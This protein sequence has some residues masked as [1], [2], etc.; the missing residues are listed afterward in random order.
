[1]RTF[2]TVTGVLSILACSSIAHAAAWTPL[3]PMSTPRSTHAATL[4]A[5]GRVLVAGGDDRYGASAEVFDPATGH[6]SPTGPMTAVRFFVAA[7]LMP[8]GKVLAVGQG[9]DGTPTPKHAE[10]YDPGTN[11]WTATSQLFFARGAATLVV[12]GD[13]RVLIAGATSGADPAEIYDPVSGRW[14][15]TGPTNVNRWFGVGVV[16]AGGRVLVFG[17][18]EA[19]S[20][21]PSIASELLDLST[22]QWRRVAASSPTG[23]SRGSATVLPSGD[24]LAV[25]WPEQG[26]TVY[27]VAR[28]AWRVGPKESCFDCVSSILDTKQ[29]L[30][31]GQSLDS[32][33]NI[34]SKAALYDEGQGRWR[35][36]EAPA[37][38][39]NRHTF[40]RLKDGTFLVAGGGGTSS[41]E[42]LRLTPNGGA[43][44]APATC[45][46]GI[47]SASACSSTCAVDGDCTPGLACQDGLCAAAAHDA[48]CAFGGRASAGADGT[49]SLLVWTLA[50]AACVLR[51]R[52]RRARV[53]TFMIATSFFVGCGDPAGT[54]S[55][56]KGDAQR[57]EAEADTDSTDTLG[58]CPARSMARPQVV[59]S[60]SCP[61]N[62]GP[63]MISVGDFCIDAFEVTNAQ[64]AEFIASPAPK[65]G[66]PTCGFN[67]SFVPSEVGGSTPAMNCP[68]AYDPVARPDNPMSCVDWCD[69]W[70][71]CAWAGKRLCGKT[72]G[73][74]HPITEETDVTKSEWLFACSSG[75]TSAYPY[76]DTFDRTA[77]SG[78]ECS[79]MTLPVGTATGCH[80][81]AAPFDQ[82]FDMIGNVEEWTDA[83]DGETGKDD[84]CA[85]RGFDALSRFRDSQGI[86]MTGEEQLCLRYARLNRGASILDNVGIRCCA[87]PLPDSDAGPVDASDAG[88]D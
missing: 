35:Q 52:R 66:H 70:S 37:V 75:G 38:L 10:I 60:P 12:L 67:A 83:C 25:G 74:P 79:A 28:D 47:C 26:V 17:G 21:S 87:D 64:Y 39:R 22:G 8:N 65:Q 3:E 84:K 7:V 32:S 42:L 2:G 86:L 51:A 69:A 71:Y 88:G 14:D 46:S 73:G 41:A 62:A 85:T 61:S 19:F 82:L 53:T 59:A 1:M 58:P 68:R 31:V 77:C 76:G 44:G 63:P 50:V 30:V 16:L 11:A 20:D 29:I 4:L 36:L 45:Y 54:S 57:S 6:W 72:G 55:I 34:A 78:I 5:D 15:T 81:A 43:C 27:D 80:G 9:P 40:T 23:E 18:Y 33:A 24:V 48:S 13:G 56:A 49:S